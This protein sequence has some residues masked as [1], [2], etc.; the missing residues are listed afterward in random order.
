MH[1]LHT[2][3]KYTHE[4]KGGLLLQAFHGENEKDLNFKFK[5]FMQS[6]PLFVVVLV[7]RRK[8]FRR[9]RSIYCSSK[10][11]IDFI[12]L[13]YVILFKFKI[14]C[15]SVFFLIFYLIKF[16]FLNFVAIFIVKID[17]Y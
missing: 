16:N 7:L 14:I 17:F 2:K 12:E 11:Y 1:L 3:A 6:D 9:S 8:L 10:F 15:S 13:F 4:T 5:N